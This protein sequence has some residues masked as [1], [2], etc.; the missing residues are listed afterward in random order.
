[1]KIKACRYISVMLVYIISTNI[2]WGFHTHDSLQPNLDVIEK[3]PRHF[4]IALK[5]NMLYDA[6]M[7]TNYSIEVPFKIKNEQLSLNFDHQFSWW[8]WGK[9]KYQ[10]S[11]C[12]LQIGGEIRWWFLPRHNKKIERDNLAGHFVG[13]YFMGGKY[14]FQWKRKFC[15]QGEFWSAGLTY[16]Y[17]IPISK[18]FNLEFAVSVGYAPIAYRHF[19][20]ADDFSTLFIDRSDMGTHHYIGITKLGV[21][22]VVPF[23]FKYKAKRR[24]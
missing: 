20:P 6:L 10:Y 18:L 8:H 19:I 3:S 7:W 13:P 17:A 5:T 9:Y 23:R 14:E 11:N 15:Y 22:L 16:G 1:M 2:V 24:R 4:D 21:N 12:Y